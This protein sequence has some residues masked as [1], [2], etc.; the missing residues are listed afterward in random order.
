MPMI[1]VTMS[2]TQGDS[3]PEDPLMVE[4]VGLL[5][6]VCLVFLS[7]CLVER[8]EVFDSLFDSCWG[9]GYFNKASCREMCKPYGGMLGCPG[10]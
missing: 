9:V 3:R 4:V 6:I 8:L 2:F 5:S 1:R 7:V 10:S